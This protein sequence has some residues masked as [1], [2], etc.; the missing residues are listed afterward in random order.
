MVNDLTADWFMKTQMFEMG[1]KWM[2]N[3]Y[4][5]TIWGKKKV[6][7]IIFP[8]RDR[9]QYVNQPFRK[10]M[11]GQYLPNSDPGDSFYIAINFI[12]FFVNDNS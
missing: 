12:V 6:S 10:I 8:Y 9:H 5:L 1:C 7:L 11:Y 2:K 4:S 3:M